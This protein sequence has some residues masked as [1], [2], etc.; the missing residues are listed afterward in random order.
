MRAAHQPQ[1]LISVHGLMDLYISVMWLAYQWTGFTCFDSSNRRVVNTALTE[2]IRAFCL[3][4]VF[5]WMIWL[6]AKIQPICHDRAR[7]LFASL[8]CEPPLLPPPPFHP[9]AKWPSHCMDVCMSVRMSACMCVCL[10]EWMRVLGMWTSLRTP[11]IWGERIFAAFSSSVS[12]F[13]FPAP[14][15]LSFSLSLLLLFLTLLKHNG[16]SCSFCGFAL[17]TVYRLVILYVCVCVWSFRRA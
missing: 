7:P 12:L 4:S 1:G 8:K 10:Y 15:S 2:L 13:S 9:L 5:L 17:Q 16:A 14:T 6:R 3:F 11:Y